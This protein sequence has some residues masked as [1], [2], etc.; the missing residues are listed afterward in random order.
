MNS[1]KN[2]KVTCKGA[3]RLSLD[4]IISFQGDLKSLSDEDAEK[5][6]R[7][8]IRYGISF[9][10]YV[11]KQNG[12]SHCLDGHQRQRVLLKM[13]DEGY[14][15]P[16]LPVDWI[17]AKDEAEAKE[18]I[19]LISSQYGKMTEDSLYQFVAG[20][21]D[22]NELLPMID[23]PQLDLIALQKTL[24]EN[25]ANFQP[26][27]AAEQGRLDQR[28]PITCPHCGEQFVPGQA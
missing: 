27:T 26:G 11:W 25:G 24:S 4:K 18:K 16:P 1:S 22:F 13:R 5:L 3:A 6:K 2:I 8:I 19:L 21:L 9:P 15:I 10:F 7:S 12:K 17:E 23:F 28:S 20:S 14:K